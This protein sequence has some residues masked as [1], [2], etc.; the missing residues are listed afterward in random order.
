MNTHYENREREIVVF[1]EMLDRYIQP[2]T[3]QSKLS[4]PYTDAVTPLQR[5]TYDTQHRLKIFLSKKSRICFV[6]QRRMP[7]SVEEKSLIEEIVGMLHEAG[8]GM[9]LPDARF[10]QES[11]ER[12]AAR[13][14]NARSADMIFQLIQV[15]KKWA[16]KSL[17]REKWTH[18]I[19][20][21]LNKSARSACNFFTLS[22]E[23]N[24]HTMGSSKGTL[25][26]MNTWGDILGIESIIPFSENHRKVQ[27]VYAPIDVADVAFWTGTRNRMAIMLTEKGEILLFK[28]RKLIFVYAFS[29]WQ[30]FPHTLL[31]DEIF[32]KRHS[33]DELDVRKAA[34]L[35][36]LDMAFH[37]RKASIG[38]LSQ[39][40]RKN[41][42]L[43]RVHSDTGSTSRKSQDALIK[44]ITHDKKFQNLSRKIRA[45]LCA[46]TGTL[47]LDTGGAF[48]IGSKDRAISSS[49]SGPDNEKDVGIK[50]NGLGILEIYKNRDIPL[51]FA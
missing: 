5:V 34:Y 15:Y 46:M 48:Y 6:M 14:M 40:H 1:R 25:L 33:K 38:I 13:F 31:V 12:V 42:Q 51:A 30:Y 26:A 3:S 7:F 17:E 50:V 27:E 18:T 20:I 23:D 9:A 22:D 8:D 16:V 44:S 47:I 32:D 4:G 43:R 49:G 35:T 24:V 11:I 37:G 45:E 29:Q 21:Y 28:N 41:N 2:L 19:G 36:S 10:V 39:P